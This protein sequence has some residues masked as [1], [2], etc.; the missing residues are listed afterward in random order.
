MEDYFLV[1]GSTSLG[2]GTVQ[3]GVIFV[4]LCY[5]GIFNRL[6]SSP[7]IV[8]FMESCLSIDLHGWGV[9]AGVS[10]TAILVTSP[11]NLM[12]AIV[13]LH[14]PCLPLIMS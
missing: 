11:W 10:Y 2:G 14:C 1:W 4:L 6:L 3:D 12:G 9:M 5:R 13:H 8:L 7:R